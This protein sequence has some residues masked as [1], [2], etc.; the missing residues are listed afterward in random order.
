MLQHGL[1][2]IKKPT[3]KQRKERKNRQKKVRGTA[4]SKI[5]AGKKVRSKV[6]DKY[7]AF[8]PKSHVSFIIDFNFQW[9]SNMKIMF[10]C[11]FLWH[12][13]VLMVILFFFFSVKT[14]STFGIT[15]SCIL[16]SIKNVKVPPICSFLVK[17]KLF[18]LLSSYSAGRY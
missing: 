14:G 9:L 2:E 8:Y 4:K 10:T 7:I 13:M 18:Y 5:G 16:L 12:T 17:P 1:L 15:F 6:N 3:R 11:Y